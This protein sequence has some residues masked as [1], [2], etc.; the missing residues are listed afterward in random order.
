MSV[1][2]SVDWQA[3]QKPALADQEL[4]DAPKTHPLESQGRLR[5]GERIA[6]PAQVQL[7]VWHQP[8][9]LPAFD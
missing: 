7:D 6:H 9:Q 3:V 4:Q 2:S 1:I 8:F 5:R